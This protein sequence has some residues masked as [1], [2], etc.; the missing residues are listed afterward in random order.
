MS[1]IRV[2]NP[3]PRSRT[4]L[5]QDEAAAALSGVPLTKDDEGGRKVGRQ[6][7]KDFMMYQQ[8][9]RHL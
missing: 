4:L 2:A 3:K 9:G 7:I 1:K 6:Q 5:G 8:Q